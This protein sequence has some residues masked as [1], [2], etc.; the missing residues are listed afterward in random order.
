MAPNTGSGANT[1]RQ[2]EKL[3]NRI[4]AM[5]TTAETATTQ[6]AQKREVRLVLERGIHI[7]HAMTATN[8]NGRSELYPWR[9]LKK[10][11]IEC[12]CAGSRVVSAFRRF[13][14]GKDE[15]ARKTG[16]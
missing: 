13:T 16:R 4:G 10:S 8:A 9:S 7:R 12:H 6:S 5:R 14:S 15:C 2:I 1:L 3:P 11:M